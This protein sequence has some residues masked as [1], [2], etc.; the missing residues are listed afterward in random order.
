M[1]FCIKSKKSIIGNPKLLYPILCGRLANIPVTN[2]T[3]SL[4]IHGP[5]IS[6]ATNTAMIFGMNASVCSWIDVVAW[7]MLTIKPTISPK[8]NIGADTNITIISASCA[9]CMTNSELIARPH[10]KLNINDR[11]NKCQPSTIT[12]N[13]TL[14][15]IEIITGG[16]IIMP[17]DISVDAT[18]ISM[19]MNGT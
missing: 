6:I 11:T 15:G 8:P 19:T 18:I 14:N 9:N 10:L 5:K 4:N 1:W 7:N 13:N 16:N 12:N 2:S 17:I 3:I